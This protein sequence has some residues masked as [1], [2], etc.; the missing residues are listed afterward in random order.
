MTLTEELRNRKTEILQ[1][2]ARHGAE[3]LSVFGSVARGEGTAAGDV[4]LLIIDAGGFVRLIGFPQRVR[5][6]RRQY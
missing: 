6:R 1:V 2:A 5:Y 3:N 4:D